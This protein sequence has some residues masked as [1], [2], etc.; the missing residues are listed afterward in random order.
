MRVTRRMNSMFVVSTLLIEI[1]APKHFALNLRRMKGVENTRLSGINHFM[2]QLCLQVIT[3]NNVRDV[4]GFAVQ[5][6]RLVPNVT[7]VYFCADSASIRPIFRFTKMV[8][9]GGACT[10]L[11]LH[12][13]IQM[14]EHT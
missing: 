5:C 13:P 8:Q 7:Q 2:N 1:T 14:N 9:V 4:S 6:R 12:E 10:F 3:N 11:K